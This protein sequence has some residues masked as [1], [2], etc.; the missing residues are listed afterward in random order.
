[1]WQDC[2]SRLLVY[3]PFSR[4]LG[5]VAYASLVDL[6]LYGNPEDNKKV[7]VVSGETSLHGHEQNDEQHW[8][9]ELFY[10]IYYILTRDK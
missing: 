2:R 4:R 7:L 5:V 3:R 6:C 9:R 1:M 10:M 8:N